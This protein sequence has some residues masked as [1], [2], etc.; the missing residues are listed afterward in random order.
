MITVGLT[1]GIG[2][3]KSTIA[4]MFEDLGVAVYYADDEAKKLMNTSPQIK[5]KLI[6]VFGEKAYENGILNR[7]FLADIVF[8]DKEKLQQINAI[9]H[10]EVDQHFK[11][12]V[13]YQK[14]DFVIQENAILF[15][16]GMQHK[17]DYIITVIAPKNVKIKRV[18]KRDKVNRQQIISRMNNQLDDAEKIKKS[19]FIINNIN[20]SQSKD[21]VKEIFMELT[22]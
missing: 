9:V 13:T 19:N 14:G 16:N 5:K 7:S 21:Q 1:G 11:N 22:N 12:W 4:K 8:N 17:F 18:I 6:E 15:E 2:S 10:P 3:G 20:L